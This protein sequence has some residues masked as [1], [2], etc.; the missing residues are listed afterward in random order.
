MLILR[1]LT[2][3]KLVTLYMY[4]ICKDSTPTE[5]KKKKKPPTQNSLADS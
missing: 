5:G 2:L 3:K 1:K 4:I